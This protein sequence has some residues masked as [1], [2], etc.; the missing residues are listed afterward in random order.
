MGEVATSS[1]VVEENNG[2]GAKPPFIGPTSAN[3]ISYIKEK[4]NKNVNK[5]RYSVRPEP[6]YSVPVDWPEPG[7]VLEIIPYF[8]DMNLK[9]SMELL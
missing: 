5:S 2:T 8:A 7:K 4:S 1:G 9:R 6:E 3:N